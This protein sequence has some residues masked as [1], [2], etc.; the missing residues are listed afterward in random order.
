ME[1]MKRKSSLYFLVVSLIACMAVSAMAQELPDGP[2]RAEVEKLC[3]QCHELARS[4]APRQ[5]RDAWTHTMN[6]MVAFGRLLQRT[7]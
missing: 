5:D 4:L 6:K 2:G 7:S 1:T 3:K